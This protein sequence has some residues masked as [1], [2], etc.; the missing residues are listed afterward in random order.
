MPQK[1]L[2]VEDD[3]D[4]AELLEY[5]L[6][7]ERFDV[8][9]CTSGSTGL[10]AA[11]ATPFDLIVLDLML[12]DIGGLDVC[13]ALRTSACTA[14]VPILILTAPGTAIDRIV[15]FEVGADD[16]LT[17]PFSPRE[18]VLRVKS[19]LRRAADKP[20]ACPGSGE[21]PLGSDGLLVFGVLSIDPARVKVVVDDREL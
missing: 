13:R 15:G 1:I 12:P 20:I 16:Y 14:T 8:A 18:L 10:A 6:N 17:K 2:I 4:I 9:I 5:N 7:Q 11:S 3:R 19:I 21:I